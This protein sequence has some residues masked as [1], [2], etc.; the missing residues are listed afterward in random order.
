MSF[1]KTLKSLLAGLLISTTSIPT[2]L[3]TSNASLI[4][5]AVLN[6]SGAPTTIVH[7][8]KEAQKEYVYDA[9][10]DLI[11]TNLIST[12]LGGKGKK[13]KSGDSKTPTHKD[14]NQGQLYTI[15][16]IHNSSNWIHPKN[17]SRK[18]YGSNFLRLDCGSWNKKGVYNPKGRC[19][20]GLHGTDEP[21]KLG[22]VASMGC[23][24]HDDKSLEELV[25]LTKIGETKVSIVEKTKWVPKTNSAGSGDELPDND[26]DPYLKYSLEDALCFANHYNKS[27]H[28][29]MYSIM[30]T[31]PVQI[32]GINCANHL[33]KRARE[34]GCYINR[35]Y[36]PAACKKMIEEI[37]Q[38]YQFDNS[39]NLDKI[40]KDIS[41]KY[42]MNVS[43]TTMYRIA[44]ESKIYRKRQS[45][46]MTNNQEKIIEMDPVIITGSPT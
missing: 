2:S 42:N 43:R 15:A 11:S 19:S 1:K 26:Q 21:Q 40:A 46:Y 36:R 4:P 9:N 13:E 29:H 39:D 35:F 20:I 38:R 33:L 22:E 41:Q 34:D 3:G 5:Q 7:I 25:E 18:P 31:S 6:Y 30:R 16:S 28:N 14:N 10:K 27:D 24:R 8:D 23:I 37:K 12:G 44:K 32:D 45:N 17:N